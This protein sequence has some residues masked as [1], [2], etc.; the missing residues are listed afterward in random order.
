[1]DR[2][3]PSTFETPGVLFFSLAVLEISVTG[4]SSVPEDHSNPS[5]LK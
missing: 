1:M 4:L 2:S 5:R 3:S